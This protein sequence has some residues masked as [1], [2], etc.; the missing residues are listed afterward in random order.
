M[1]EPSAAGVTLRSARQT[2]TLF[3]S[4]PFPEQPQSVRGRRPTTTGLT[5]S[6]E[7][8]A[9]NFGLVPSNESIKLYDG[10]TATPQVNCTGAHERGDRRVVRAVPA[11]EAKLRGR[12]TIVVPFAGPPGSEYPG[13]SA[14]LSA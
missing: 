14:R 5:R 2:G 4:N 10:L 13:I 12:I 9:F 1:T 7:P 8:G 11:G 3:G 6:F